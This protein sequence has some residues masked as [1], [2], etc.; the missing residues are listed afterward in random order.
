VLYNFTGGSDGGSPNSR[1]TS[2]T[3]GNFYGT[4]SS[5]GLGYGTVFELSPNSNRGWNETVLYSFTGGEDG[6]NPLSYLIF[7]S[8]GNLYGTA[9]GGGANGYGVVFELS[10]VETSWTET[11]LHSFAG[12]ADGAEPESGL[13][14]DPAGNLYGTTVWSGSGAG[15]TVFELSPSASGWTEQVIY[16]VGSSSGLTMDASGNI[17]G[18]T[19]EIVFELSPNG[20]GGWN[21]TAI[22]SFACNRR[23]PRG[24]YPYGTLVLDQARNLYG[25]TIY[26]GAKNFGTVYRLSPGNGAWTE[27]VLHSFASLEGQ[28][29]DGRYPQGGIVLDGYGSIYGATRIGGNYGDGTVFEIDLFGDSSRERVLW[30]FSGTDGLFPAGS[31]ILGGGGDLYGTAA[32]G[33]SASGVVFKVTPRTPQT[34]TTLTSSSNPS[35]PGQAVTFTAVVSSSEGPPPDGETVTFT[36]FNKWVLGTGSL[37]GGSASF[38]ISTLRPGETRVR[39]VYRGDPDFRGCTSLRLRQEVQRLTTTIALASSPNPSTYGQAVTFTAVVTSRLGA[40]PDGEIIWFMKGQT[41]LGT[42]ALSGGSASF[43]TSTLPAST[44]EVTAV[45]GRDSDFLGSK[46]NTVKQVV[47][48]NPTAT[49][50]SSSPNPSNYVQAVTFTAAVTSAGLTPTGKVKFL[51]GTLAIGTVTVSGGVAT[52]TTAPLLVG[53]HAITAQYLGDAASAESTSSVLYQVVVVR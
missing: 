37:S 7:D 17:F 19:G 12:G 22:Y 4:T 27:K 38:T 50:L 30:S 43:T 5:G 6:A 49:A 11:V 39:A 21:P 48:K 52:L 45:Y 13:I 34:L 42:G 24:T 9:S 26:G 8:V 25:T 3:A 46:S 32:G 20:N 29:R 1:L 51:D 2:D 40:P 44:P 23:C 53:T 10:P 16:A 28:P 31:L 35:V 47:V 41:V 36:A 33:L 14:M 15:G 18:L